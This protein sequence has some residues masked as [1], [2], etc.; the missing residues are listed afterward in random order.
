VN[1]RR[2]EQTAAAVVRLMPD[3]PDGGRAW[4]CTKRNTYPDGR[5]YIGTGIVPA[6]T[7]P[8]AA[9]DVVVG[10]DAALE[11]ALAILRERVPPAR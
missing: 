8:I 2:G 10:R 7:V 3:L 4:I 6:V 9:A 5:T 1:R 11:I